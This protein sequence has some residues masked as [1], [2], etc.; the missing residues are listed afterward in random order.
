MVSA[1]PQCA[2]APS[3]QLNA[4]QVALLEYYVPAPAPRA[5]GTLCLN[6]T[7]MVQA[8]Y[9]MGAAGGEGAGF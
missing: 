2:L 4:S 7:A 8:L 3:V 5:N 6:L 1:T 9:D